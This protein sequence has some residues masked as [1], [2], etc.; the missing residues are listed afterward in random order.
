MAFVPQAFLANYAVHGD[1]SKVS[2]FAAYIFPPKNLESGGLFG[3]LLPLPSFLNAASLSFQCEAAELPGYNI[4]TIEGKVYGAAYHVAATPVFN[5]LNLTFI[6]AG[7]LWEKKF[8]DDWMDLVLPKKTSGRTGYLASFFKDYSSSIRVVQFTEVGIPAYTVQF[9]QAYPYT[10]QPM[11]TNW[12]DDGI[13]RLSVG[14][15]YTEWERKSL[16]GELLGK[17]SDMIPAPRTGT[18]D[19]GPLT[20]T[21]EQR[22]TQIRG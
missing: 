17:I 12:A 13:H 22:A 19:V 8:F 18:V 1:F 6:C 7:D 2:K 14:F 11:Q 5:E 4:N 21:P 3:G 16:V 10:M 20:Q 9:E 15:R